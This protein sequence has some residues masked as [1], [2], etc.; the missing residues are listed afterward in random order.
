MWQGL[1]GLRNTTRNEGNIAGQPGDCVRQIGQ[2]ANENKG[3]AGLGNHE[4][5]CMSFGVH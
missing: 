5:A 2:E 1:V 3:H 4:E